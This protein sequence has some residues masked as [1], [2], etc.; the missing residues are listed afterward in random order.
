MTFETTLGDKFS[1]N[2]RDYIADYIDKYPHNN[3]YEPEI[4]FYTQRDI[5]ALK[6]CRTFM[7][8][9]TAATVDI[10]PDKLSYYCY[11]DCFKRFANVPY[12][13]GN[14][15]VP[16]IKDTFSN[17]END[18]LTISKYNNP[19]VFGVSKKPTQKQIENVE[20]YIEDVLNYTN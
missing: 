5:N 2:D 11:L 14:M 3:R 20:K 17:I 8:E 4:L 19:L 12:Y 6:R 1:L 7:K 18:I 10:N 9:R 16:F 15:N 13:L